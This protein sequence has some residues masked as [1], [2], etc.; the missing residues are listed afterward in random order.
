[1]RRSVTYLA[2]S[3][4]EK[5]NPGQTKDAFHARVKAALGIRDEK[6]ENPRP[7]TSIDRESNPAPDFFEPSRL[8]P[9]EPR[10]QGVSEP[11]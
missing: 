2:N 4:S 11:T 3:F 10:G 7:L 9:C 8:P 6:D 1:M 5:P